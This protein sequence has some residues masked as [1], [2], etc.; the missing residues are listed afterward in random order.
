MLIRKFD[1]W[2]DELCTC[3]EKYSL[4]P[5]TGCEHRCIYCYITS[6]VPNGFNCR[7]KK[8][9]LSSVRND[10]KKLKKG[11][12]IALSNSSDPYTPMEKTHRL[13]RECLKI[14]ENFM[15]MIV[16][17]SDLVVRDIDLLRNM[18]AGVSI[19]ITSLDESTTKKLEPFAPEPERRLKALEKL[20]GEGV[21]ASCR[22]DPIIPGINENAEQLVKELAD[23]GVKHVVSS[24]FKPRHD[25]WKRFEKTFEADAK[26]LKPLYSD[27]R[28]NTYYLPSDVRYR[29]MKSVRDA[30]EKHGMTFAACREGLE[31]STAKSC[32]GS[33]LI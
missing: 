8:N 11:D 16:T 32:D 5:Y 1:P 33:H 6:Y 31:L 12:M 25:S 24:T 29:L 20:V 23:V 4:N 21:G 28:R 10:A 26:K 3:P 9:L 27:R 2:G 18:R 14:L 19:T 17:K 30:C 7:V 15:V 13:T 22:I